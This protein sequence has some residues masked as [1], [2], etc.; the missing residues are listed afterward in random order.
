MYVD[1]WNFYW[2]LVDAGIKPYGW[3]DFPLLA[4]QQTYTPDAEVS[5]K[6]FTSP[7]EPH[8]EKIAD[9]Q[10]PIWWQALKFIGCHIIQGEFRSTH[11]EVE[12]QIRFSNKSWREKQTD[13]ALASHMV[14]DCSQIEPGIDP[15]VF[16]WS[17][18]FDRA[19]LLSQDTDFIPLVRIVSGEPFFR[20]V[21]VLLPPSGAPAQENAYR[22]WDREAKGTRVVVK[23]LRL[24]DLAHA[25]LPRV[26]ESQMGDKVACHQTWMWREKHESLSTRK[27]AS[28]S[29]FVAN[30]PRSK[31]PSKPRGNR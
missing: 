17:P 13:I 22:T 2:A 9:R 11:E 8:H 20:P 6:Y 21:L 31:D 3:C 25:L 30:S 28:K 18:G 19:V 10:R 15:G 7:D 1:G 12:E 24:P 23:Q 14:K 4:R 27:I 16:R 26:V 5:V 29:T